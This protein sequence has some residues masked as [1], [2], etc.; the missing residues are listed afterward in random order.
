[1]RLND[2]LFSPGGT[3]AICGLDGR[4]DAQAFLPGQPGLL[5]SRDDLQEG[6]HH[7]PVGGDLVVGLSEI[8]GRRRATLQTR[9]L[10]AHMNVTALT[11]NRDIGITAGRRAPAQHNLPCL[12]AGRN[13]VNPRGLL[14]FETLRPIL[15]ACAHPPDAPE[16]VVDQVERMPAV[17]HDD[18]AA[19]YR[20]LRVPAIRHRRRRG[21]LDAEVSHRADFSRAHQFSGHAELGHVPVLGGD[22]QP[23][24]RL[25]SHVPQLP[26]EG[27]I[28]DQRLLAQHVQPPLQAARGQ[29][30]VAGGRRAN[31]HRIGP[32]RFQHLVQISERWDSQLRSTAARR[33]VRITGARQFHP[34]AIAP[35]LCV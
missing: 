15:R 33:R 20:A 21:E 8:H 12:A 10:P 14:H 31:A 34:R 19:G 30:T 27:K 16:H 6:G 23:S 35:R 26:R 22:K 29:L 25:R 17:I 5:P 28:R 1:V 18:A 3:G 4:G 2:S 11:P 7:A 9:A 32:R 13:D 24:V